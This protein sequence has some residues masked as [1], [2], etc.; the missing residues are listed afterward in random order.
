MTWIVTVLDGTLDDN[1]LIVVH[2]KVKDS[3]FD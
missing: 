1:N 2:K 3:L